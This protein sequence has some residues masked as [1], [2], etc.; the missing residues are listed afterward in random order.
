[1]TAQRRG[2]SAIAA[3]E[4]LL[5]TRGVDVVADRRWL[6]AYRFERASE[7]ERTAAL[8]AWAAAEE[9]VMRDPAAAAA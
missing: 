8:L 7:G 4:A 1:M 3:L 6:F 9:G 2:R 5:A